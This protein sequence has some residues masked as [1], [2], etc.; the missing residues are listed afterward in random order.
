MSATGERDPKLAIKINNI[1]TENVLECARLNDI[2][3]Y[4]PSSIAAFGPTTPQD[5]TPNLTVMR[6][7]TIYGITKI[8]TELLGEYYHKKYNVDFRSLRYPGIISN[9]AMPGGGTTDY[10]VEI[11]HDAL[12]KG[13]YKCF[14]NRDQILPM[15]YMPDCIKATMDIMSADNNNLTERVYNVTGCSFTPNEQYLSIKEILPDFNIEYHPDFR[16]EIAQTWPHSID[17]NQARIDWNWD[18]K[19]DLHS[20]TQ[21]MLDTLS[22]KYNDTNQANLKML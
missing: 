10:A 11:Y 6:P 8:Y 3:V 17:D 9:K 22:Q 21:D 12:T 4:I 16:Q 5:N 1:G 20:M 15:M 13:K 7:T 14:L 2:R 19:F 18:P